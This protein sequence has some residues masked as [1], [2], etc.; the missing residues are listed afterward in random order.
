M[1]GL[2]LVC[3][4]SGCPHPANCR[5]RCPIC[6]AERDDTHNEA[7]QSIPAA[8]EAPSLGVPAGPFGMTAK[9][10][11]TYFAGVVVFP[12]PDLGEGDE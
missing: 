8:A 4:C 2:P 3:A 1:S 9:E 11:D 6:Q 7:A 12:H 5:C 10:I